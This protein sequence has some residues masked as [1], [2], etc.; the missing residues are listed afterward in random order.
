[1]ELSHYIVKLWR[2]LVQLSRYFVKVSRYNVKLTHYSFK[3]QVIKWNY[4]V[5]KVS[6]YNKKLSHY[7]VRRL[8][9]FVKASCYN[10]NSEPVFFFVFFFP[11]WHWY[12]FVLARTL[13]YVCMFELQR[14]RRKRWQSL[15]CLVASV[16]GVW[17]CVNT[18]HPRRPHYCQPCRL[19]LTQFFFFHHPPLP[20]PFCPFL[21][22]SPAGN[23]TARV[24]T[25]EAGSDE[26][27]KSILEQAKRELQV[28][29][30]GE[31]LFIHF[32][33]RSN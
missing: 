28:Q 8:R 3:N 1:M 23:I 16:M 5:V 21:P 2:Y 26:A 11:R 4:Y 9:Y 32:H 27:I 31:F 12:A 18:W 14:K 13:L 20:Q 22:P 24:R 10:M 7:N 30:A 6:H 15:Q 17:C 25:P 19:F 33:Q 29:K